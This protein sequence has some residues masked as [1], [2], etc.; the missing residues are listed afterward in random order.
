[1]IIEPRLID[2]VTHAGSA[3][4]PNEDFLIAENGLFVVLD[5]A[6]GLGNQ[7]VKSH[8]SDAAWFVD[9]FSRQLVYTWKSTHNFLS[10][11]RIAIGNINSNFLKVTKNLTIH[12]YELPSAGMTALVLN[13][14]KLELYRT[15]DCVAYYS[16]GC[17][18]G[19]IFKKSKLE[20]LDEQSTKNLLRKMKE[21][22]SYQN[23][24]LSILN[25]LRDN[26]SM[27]NSDGG[28]SVLTVDNNCINK[29]ETVVI[30][31]K[32][33]DRFLLTTDG[34]GSIIDKYKKYTIT[35]LFNHLNSHS[36]KAVIN[37][38]REI[39]DNDSNLLTYPRLK[40][41]DDASALLIEV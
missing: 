6:T 2:K 7:L 11:V 9:E 1:M 4:K 35:E 13:Q 40:N 23:A 37:E 38:I 36:L 24:R 34:F 14:S 5:G 8:K 16:N 3:S 19:S 27:M 39:E 18:S 30:N 12:P 17:D 32:K 22:S 29:I 33:G 41:H 28:Y 26:R 15:G 25:M 21:G 31:A 20:Q 10:S